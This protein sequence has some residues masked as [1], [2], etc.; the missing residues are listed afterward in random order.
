MKASADK[1]LESPGRSWRTIR[2]EVSAPAM[3]RR[4]H[5][6]RLFAWSKIGALVLLLGGAGW[7]GYSL[8][9]SW[10]SR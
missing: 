5:R 4:G 8:F 6:R 2:Q 3:S 7:G 9:H 1:T 10:E